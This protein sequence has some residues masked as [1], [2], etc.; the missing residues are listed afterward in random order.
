MQTAFN[1]RAFSNP[2]LETSNGGQADPLAWMDAVQLTPMQPGAVE[3]P[4]FKV[5]PLLA[6]ANALSAPSAGFR[7]DQP[8]EEA[9]WE[10]LFER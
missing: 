4:L 5:V 9:A 8:T 10:F 6:P 1:T 2:G 3:I 7:P